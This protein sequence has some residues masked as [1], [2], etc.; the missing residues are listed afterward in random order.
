MA[1]IHCVTG[2]LLLTVITP[3]QHIKSSDPNAAAEMDPNV[4]DHPFG[5]FLIVRFQIIH[6]SL[7]AIP[8]A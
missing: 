5:H 8:D 3:S 4:F 1:A 7:I 2:R 6:R